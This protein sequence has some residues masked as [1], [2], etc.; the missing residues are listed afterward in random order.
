ML[1]TKMALGLWEM[2]HEHA[3]IRK[4]PPSVLR[5]PGGN[6]AGMERTDGGRGKSTCLHG[7]V[8]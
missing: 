6:R 4:T 2:Q 8:F 3:R 7:V 5:P 1:Q